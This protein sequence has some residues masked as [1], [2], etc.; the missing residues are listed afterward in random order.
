M[1]GKPDHIKVYPVEIC[2]CCRRSLT[3]Q[4]LERVEKRQVYD[5]PPRWL[6]VTEHQ[7][8]NRLCNAHH[9]RE[10]I[11]VLEQY[12]QDWADHM[13]E[14]LLEIKD[15]VDQARQT[16]G[17]LDKKQIRDFEARYQQIIDEGDASNPLQPLS[18]NA[19]KKRGRRKKSK[20]R[21]LLERLDKH[22]MEALAFMYDFNVP[23][24]N[25]QAER[26]IRMMKVQQKTSG[27]FRTEDGAK[28]FCG[29]RS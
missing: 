4:E 10:L 3:G 24:D 23:F 26:D 15:A 1:A 16:T 18:L 5:L 29:I 11:F 8:E 20:P 27:M 2:E 22:R 21:N 14:R 13:I 19:K 7:A 28:A 6:I 9:P 12:K 17:H 25:N